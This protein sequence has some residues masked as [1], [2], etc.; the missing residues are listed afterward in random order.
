MYAFFARPFRSM[1]KR[2]MLILLINFVL[3]FMMPYLR[4]E[5]IL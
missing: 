2:M 3:H 5:R 4:G 1:E